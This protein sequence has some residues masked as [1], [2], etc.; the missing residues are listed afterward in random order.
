MDSIIIVGTSG[1]ARELTEW[2]S[3]KFNVVGFCGINDVDYRKFNYPGSF[4]GNDMTPKQVGTDMVMMA[5]GQPEIKNRLHKQLIEQGFQFPKFCHPNSV[6]A[7]S[8]K[9]S[10][11]A[12]VAPGCV[13][14][15]NVE[16]G[17]CSYIN[18]CVGVGH[19]AKIGDFCQI[20]PGAQIGG[21]AHIGDKTLVGSGAT[22]LENLHVG[23]GATIGSGAS[24]MARVRDNTTVM[25]QPARKLRAFG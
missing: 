20:N 25:G 1:L 21:G 22:V 14:G 19:E 7:R 8:A 3:D 18:F 24:V 17:V 15:P 13:V 9:L 2:I 4:S 10:P 12:I 11:G 23:S 16:L 5:I 6:V